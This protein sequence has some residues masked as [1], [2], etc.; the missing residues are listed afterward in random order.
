MLGDD[1]SGLGSWIIDGMEWAAG[2]GAQVVNLSLGTV[3]VGPATVEVPAGG[4]TR[5]QLGAQA[6]A[7][8]LV[9]SR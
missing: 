7:R 4:N 6:A 1:G 5:F 2:Q 3:T 9:P 8:G